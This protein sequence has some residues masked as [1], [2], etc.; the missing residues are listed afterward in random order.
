M[1][2]TTGTYVYMKDNTPLEDNLETA[3]KIQMCIPST[4]QLCCQEF[5]LHIQQQVIYVPGN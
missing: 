1:Y 5:I 4:Q 3:V 2:N